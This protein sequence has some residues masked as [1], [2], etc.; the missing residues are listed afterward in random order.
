[1]W[2]HHLDAR[3][4][5][6]LDRQPLYR[7]TDLGDRTDYTLVLGAAAT[8]PSGGFLG[9]PAI[10]SRPECVLHSAKQGSQLGLPRGWVTISSCSWS[11]ILGASAAY[12]VSCTGYSCPWDV[13]P[14]QLSSHHHILAAE[15]AISKGLVELWPLLG[16]LHLPKDRLCPQPG[17]S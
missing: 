13:T 15:L 6:R 16:P 2:P 9:L 10:S 12:G 3:A 7:G 1:M 8:A 11:L 5:Q 14:G 4:S 17:E